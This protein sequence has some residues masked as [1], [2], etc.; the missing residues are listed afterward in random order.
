MQLER[1]K[2]RVV[3]RRFDLVCFTIAAFV[4]VDAFASVAKYG[5]GQALFWFVVASIFYLV[6]SGLIT[7]E[8]GST[9]PIEGSPYA[10]PRLAFGR[11]AGAVTA[12]W[13]W[14]GNPT[15]IGGT[16]AAAVVATMSS[17]LMFNHSF[18]T[19]WSIVIGTAVVWAIVGFAIIELK[20]G[21][22]TGNIGAF[23]RIAVLAV[24]LALAAAFLIK[25]GKPAGT[26][27]L[28]SLKPTVPGFLGVF[29]LLQFFLVG[30][31]LSN[32][33]SEEMRNPQRDVPAMIVRSGIWIVAINLLFI[34]GMLLVIP[35]TGFSNV[36]GFVDAYGVVA[37]VLG[38][39]TGPIGWIMGILIILVSLTIG[40]VWIQGSAR[41][42]AVA[43]LDGAAPLLLGKFTKAGTPLSMNIASGFVGTVFVVLVF[44]L[45]SGSLGSFFAVMFS[46]VISLTAIQYVFIFPA[47]IVLRRKY[48]DR[49][50]PYRIPGGAVGMW[51]CVIST[52]VVIV[53]TTIMLLWPGLIDRVF[54]GRSYSMA[55]NWGVSRFFFEAVTLGTFAAIIVQ[56]LVFYALGRRNVAKG[57]VK[58]NELLEEAPA[59]TPEAEL[60]TA[61]AGAPL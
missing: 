50:R 36:S 7:A 6:P 57:I 44:T 56:G 60:E 52:E 21:K 19:L 38:S 25:H 53:L 46:I 22:L 27:T 34:F 12:T 42:Q 28:G 33:A 54:F 49:R 15:W 40:G 61:P 23:V 24:F 29:G 10:W 5:G 1:S 30:F 4:G 58:E 20:Y 2:L 13:Y 43:G 9:F 37:G 3:L 14:M 47:V 55:A 51:A 35:L 45:T 16:L 39:A 32:S 41:T 8:L 59:A 18:G 48:P 11:M 31:E 26:I 17:K